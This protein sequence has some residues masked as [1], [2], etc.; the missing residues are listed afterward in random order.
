M[1]T[2]TETR[3]GRGIRD[4]AALAGV[5]AGV[6]IHVTHA[7][8]ARLGR[9]D[10]RGLGREFE[11]FEDGLH[12]RRMGDERDH[13]ATSTAKLAVKDVER[14]TALVPSAQGLGSS[15]RTRPSS[16]QARRSWATAGLVM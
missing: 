16:C 3:D 11:G 8:R 6:R 14:T 12:C 7:G 15:R 4:H 13:S 1:K 5:V 10:G 2:V 9:G